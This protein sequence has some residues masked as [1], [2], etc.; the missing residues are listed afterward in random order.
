MF[1]AR[2]SGETMSTLYLKVDSL[3]LITILY[4]SFQLCITSLYAILLLYNM[5]RRKDLL[6]FDNLHL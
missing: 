6:L 1:I 2:V 4:Y 5:A 3:I